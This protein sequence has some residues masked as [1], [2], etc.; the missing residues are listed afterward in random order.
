[1]RFGTNG[2]REQHLLLLGT[3]SGFVPLTSIEQDFLQH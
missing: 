3:R 1:M 2:G